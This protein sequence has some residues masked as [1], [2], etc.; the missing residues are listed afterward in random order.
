MSLSRHLL[1]ETP[2][3]K[4]TSFWRVRG[5]AQTKPTKTKEEVKK[6][7]K[8]NFCVNRH[9]KTENRKQNL[10]VAAIY[11]NKAYVPSSEMTNKEETKKKKK[12][13]NRRVSREPIECVHTYT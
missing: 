7:N 5:Q 9:S 2:V 4:S 11:H 13:Q 3:N 1:C 8:Q 6:T 10:K 12:M